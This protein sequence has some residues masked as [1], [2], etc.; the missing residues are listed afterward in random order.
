MLENLEEEAKE[1]LAAISDTTRR[2]AR[3]IGRAFPASATTSQELALRMLNLNRR[4]YICRYHVKNSKH[5]AFDEP[6]EELEGRA[7]EFSYNESSLLV[8][9]PPEGFLHCGCFIEDE[10]ISFYLWKLVPMVS[11][12]PDLMD[13]REPQNDGHDILDTRARTLQVEEFKIFSG[14]T[15][16]DLYN[17]GPLNL[18]DPKTFRQLR[19]RQ[20]E[21]FVGE[22]RALG[23]DIKVEIGNQ[24]F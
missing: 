6:D 5:D 15:A 18:Q 2:S 22:L 13:V 17:C 23:V 16:D 21:K 24:S 7:Y 11:R 3:K 8:L 9:S 10:L 19:I 20:I 14:L 1:K 4:N 12:H